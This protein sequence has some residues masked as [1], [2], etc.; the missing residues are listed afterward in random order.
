LPV[1]ID[2]PFAV[3]VSGDPD[4][5][6]R[7]AAFERLRVLTGLYSGALPWAALRDGF[8][9]DDRRFLFASAAEGIFKPREMST[10]L[11]VKT[12][13]PKARG[14][15]WYSDQVDGDERISSVGDVLHYSFT[16]TDPG[17]TRNQLLRDALERQ[18]PIIYFYGVAPATYEPLFPVFVVNW[19]QSRLAVSLAVSMPTEEAAIDWAPPEPAVRRYAMR[20]AKQRLHQAMFRERVVDAYGRRCALSGLPEIRLLDAAHIMPDGD[21]ALGQPDVRNGILMSRIHHSA[22]DTGLLGIDPDCQIH[23][24]ESLMEMHDGSMLEGIKALHG[25]SLRVPQNDKFRPDRDRLA[26]RFEGFNRSRDQLASSPIS[27]A[28][29]NPS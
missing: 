22:Y 10:L 14:R 13:V 15:V 9:V 4:A 24:A 5:R 23:I 6:I 20:I 3:S 27:Y 1:P 25:R 26:L 19:D 7:L 18:L 21:E 8:Y 11:S 12:V 16:G 28:T 17:N 2:E 29:E